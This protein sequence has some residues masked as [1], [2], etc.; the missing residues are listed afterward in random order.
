MPAPPAP[1]QFG[2]DKQDEARSYRDRRSGLTV[3]PYLIHLIFMYC[4]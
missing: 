1:G 4:G 3:A 2:K